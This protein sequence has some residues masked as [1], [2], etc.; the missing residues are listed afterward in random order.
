MGLPST[1]AWAAGTR[2]VGASFD[3]PIMAPAGPSRQSS[4]VL[5][6][7]MLHRS[8]REPSDE[9]G[10]RLQGLTGPEESPGDGPLVD[11]R[12]EGIGRQRAG[13]PVLLDPPL[14]PAEFG[15]DPAREAA[16]RPVEH[17]DEPDVLLVL[18]RRMARWPLFEDRG[19]TF[20][21]PARRDRS[22]VSGLILIRLGSAA[23]PPPGPEHTRPR[24]T[25]RSSR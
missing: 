5:V 7:V 15:E 25:P 6:M 24:S 20:Q 3:R 21:P 1:A 8:R 11:A 14:G 19:R 9:L 12:V 4:A 2:P 23:T 13:Q 17:L 16:L 10:V 22:P 18:P